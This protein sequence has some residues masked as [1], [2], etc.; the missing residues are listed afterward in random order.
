VTANYYVIGLFLALASSISFA[1]STSILSRPLT[2]SDPSSA[3]YLNLLV[4]TAI[5]AVATISF[6]QAATLTSISLVAIVIFAI[7]GLFHFNI[8]RLL[9]FTAVKNIGA[10]QTAPITATQVPYSVILAVFLLN[11]KITIPIIGGVV[12]ILSGL[13]L[14]R[15]GTGAKIR[16]GN[17]KAG[18][19][20]ASSTGLI[21]GCTPILINLGLSYFHFFIAATLLAY[22]AAFISYVPVVIVKHSTTKIRELPRS[23]LYAYVLSGALLVTAQLLRF[24]ALDYAPVV[25]VVPVLAVFPIFIIIFTWMIA[26]D[27]EIFHKKTILSIILTTIGTI[28]VSL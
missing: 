4:G 22:V 10:N 5:A 17:A 11:E 7:V 1:G 21:W 27:V 14:M 16:G 23:T 25:T 12:L 26:K 24:G 19:L 20:A 6:G 9:N 18:Y 15:A 8:S 28:L 2:K 3:N 13:T